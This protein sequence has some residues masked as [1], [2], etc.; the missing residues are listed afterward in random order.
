MRR[1]GLQEGGGRN[2]CIDWRETRGMD[3]DL[4][5]SRPQGDVASPPPRDDLP[6]TRP[7]D[8]I[9]TDRW[10]DPPD[11]KSRVGVWF[12]PLIPSPRS[13][14]WILFP[15]L[16]GSVAIAFVA[17]ALFVS[18]GGLEPRGEP[19][20]TIAIGASSFVVGFGFFIGGWMPYRRMR[21][22]DTSL[23]K[24][25][26]IIAVILATFPFGLGFVAVATILPF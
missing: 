21:D 16:T 7:K 4:P 19:W 9:S 1:E 2:V 6:R 3:D 15:V 18:G 13:P 22:D 25:A 14:W 26:L 24:A 8:D 20:N 23:G 10:V 17:L 5:A 11:P 12:G